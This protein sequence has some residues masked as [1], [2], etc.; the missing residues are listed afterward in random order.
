M[1]P[2][3]QGPAVRTITETVPTIQQ[4]ERT[5]ISAD[6]VLTVRLAQ[7]PGPQAVR[8]AIEQLIKRH[9]VLRSHLAPGPGGVTGRVQRTSARAPMC[10]TDGAG[11]SGP[12]LRGECPDSS[13]TVVLRTG[14]SEGRVELRIS[15]PANQIDLG[16]Q[17]V[18]ATELAALLQGRELPPDPV[19]NSQYAAWQADRQSVD[20][21]RALPELFPVP[22]SSVAS[23]TAYVGAF[24]HAARSVPEETWTVVSSAAR[25][26]EAEVA[27]LALALWLGVLWRAHGDRAIAK[28]AVYFDHRRVYPD[29]ADTV[30]VLSRYLPLG[31]EITA[32]DTLRSLVTRVVALRREILAALDGFSWRGL[33]EGGHAC[34]SRGP[35]LPALFACVRVDPAVLANSVSLVEPSHL[36]GVSFQLLHD[37]SSAR[38]EILSA[39]TAE[40]A[41]LAGILA[42]GFTAALAAVAAGSLDS[43]G[44]L[45]LLTADQ[46]AE[47]ANRYGRAPET[48]ALPERTIHELFAEQAARTPDR[49]AIVDTA[50]RWSYARLATRASAVAAAI[51]ERRPA[52]GCP[53]ALMMNRGADM[54]AGVLGIWQSGHPYVPIDPATPPGRA[55]FILRDSG[56]G[57]LLSDV[58]GAECLAPTPCLNPREVPDSLAALP[59]STRVTDRAA[60]YVIYTSGTTGT[61][62]GV[63][64]EHRSAVNL[65]RAHRER[66]YRHHDPDGVGLRASFNAP[67]AFDGAVERIL[68]LL[69]G[70]TLYLTDDDTRRDPEAFVA[71]AR[72][73]AL[74]VLDVT[75]AFLALLLRFGLDGGSG[76]RPQAV[77][78]GGEAIS[79]GLWRELTASEIA[80]YNVYGPT[81]CT[82]NAAVGLVRGARPHLGAALP[83]LRLYILDDAGQV[84]PA[85]VP[86]EI[87]VAGIGLARGYHER[88]G[89]TAGRFRANRYDGGDPQYARAYAT[90]DVGSFRKDGTIEFSGR[91]DGQV[92]LRGYRIETA[93][94][95]SAL[96]EH[97][98]V[99]DAA[100]RLV[101][102]GGDAK[103]VAYVVASSDQHDHLGDTLGDTLRGSLSERLPVYMVPSAVQVLTAFP[104]TGNG[105]IDFD[106]LPEP[107]PERRPGGLSSRYRPAQTDLQRALV[108]IWEEVLET[109]DVGIDDAFFEV[110]GHSLLVPVMTEV[111]RRELG[112]AL[113]VR[114]IFTAPTI[115]AISRQIDPSQPA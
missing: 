73:H 112:A 78:V 72:E 2:P 68:L 87:H 7:Y 79:Q 42:D 93:E 9:E 11:A 83:N 12:L 18:L 50:G 39:Q 22:E 16:G 84:V 53:I 56:A 81:E 115:A 24:D 86:G 64:V 35:V 92:K 108:R 94:I 98:A 8:A 110:G 26:L 21:E 100:I 58:A 13:L 27:D 99:A 76:Y 61:P 55:E 60:A 75:P 31:M 15:I 25:R 74:E 41:W 36:P 104:L 65:A 106:A 59:Q 48:V 10:W 88:P 101:S 40:S 70:N 114:T 90:G 14:G 85:G 34:D 109:R 3:R 30:G 29:L 52:A 63:V 51:A 38:I 45:P 97:P 95:V 20:S 19:Q 67:L 89:L 71:F 82:V 5:E 43:I 4:S 32:D 47:F 57:L 6:A 111:V 33:P 49:A 113:P 46:Q 69:S 80:C 44:T 62:K 102:T 37:E 23:G 28:A 54:V 66:I 105:K 96:G 107:V 1:T 103:L 17:A 91:R 77:L